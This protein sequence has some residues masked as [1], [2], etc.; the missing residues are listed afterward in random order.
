MFS[1][2]STSALPHKTKLSTQRYHLH[3]FRYVGRMW[4]EISNKLPLSMII[5]TLK[6]GIECASQNIYLIE[7]KDKRS[8][9]FAVFC[10]GRS[11]DKGGIG[12]AAAGTK[13]TVSIKSRQRTGRCHPSRGRTPDADKWT[14]IWSDTRWS[15]VHSQLM[16][17]L[18]K[19][20]NPTSLGQLSLMFYSLWTGKRL[21]QLI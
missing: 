6:L 13:M 17:S 19:T 18:R 1:L 11:S 12:R 4:N 20:K 14:A 7:I 16:Q 2:W 5:D 9:E 21:T 3:S 15:Y 10:N 8:N